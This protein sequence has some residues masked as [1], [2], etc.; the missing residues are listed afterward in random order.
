[1][2]QFHQNDSIGSGTGGR[3]GLAP[4]ARFW[5]GLTPTSGFRILLKISLSNP[6]STGSI[7][8][9]NRLMKKM[10]HNFASI[11]STLFVIF[12]L[13]FGRIS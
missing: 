10:L 13:E 3:M 8:E 12:Y 5:R 4:N 7:V 11:L 6:I 2:P 9:V 1:M